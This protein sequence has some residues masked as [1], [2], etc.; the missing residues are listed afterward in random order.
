MAMPETVTG[1]LDVTISDTDPR[2][3]VRLLGSRG[4]IT[5]GG[6]SCDGFFFLRGQNNEERVRL[7]GSAGGVYAGGQGSAGRLFLRR[8]I[9]HAG[10]PAD[11]VAMTLDASTGNIRAGGNG[12]DGDLLLFPDAATDINQDRQATIW[13]DSGHANIGVGGNG[14]DGDIL[15]FPASASISTTDTTHANIWLDADPGNVRLKGGLIPKGDPVSDT[16]LPGFSTDEG[17]TAAFQG[18]QRFG[19][20]DFTHEHPESSG[21]REKLREIWIFNPLLHANSIVLVTAHHGSPVTHIVG[22]MARRH[23]I[24][25]GV[26][27]FISLTLVRKLSPGT[28]VRIPYWIMN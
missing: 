24:S 20:I 8:T 13:L 15:L 2:T 23:D 18:S 3:T 1:Q 16:H 4:H 10:H 6:N 7:D 12:M 21:D 22:N 25:G 5:A 19:V 17:A 9:T 28:H 14:Q 26:G 11:R 27:R